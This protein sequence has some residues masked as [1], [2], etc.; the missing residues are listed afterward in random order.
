VQVNTTTLGCLFKITTMQYSNVIMVTSLS[1]IDFEV[2]RSSLSE[3]YLASD[4]RLSMMD[5]QGT[6][7]NAPQLVNIPISSPNSTNYTIYFKF[8]NLDL[9][10]VEQ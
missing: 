6:I 10:L 7:N 9:P 4:P 5:L 8:F 1:P 2:S 3:M